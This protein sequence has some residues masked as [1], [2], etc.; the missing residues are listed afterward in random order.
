VR[1]YGALWRADHIRFDRDR[2]KTF[3]EGK[4]LIEKALKFLFRSGYRLSG[5][6]RIRRRNCEE[7]AADR[8]RVRPTT[9]W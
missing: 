4:Y 2:T 9:E 5:C 3:S 8:E 7:G 6:V 1:S